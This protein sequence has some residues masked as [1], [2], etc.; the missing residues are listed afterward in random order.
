MQKSRKLL[1]TRQTQNLMLHVRPCYWFTL[2]LQYK[3]TGFT[4]HL[5]QCFACKQLPWQGPNKKVANE[6]YRWHQ[7]KG[8]SKLNHIYICSLSWL[9][10]YGAFRGFWGNFFELVAFIRVYY[11]NWLSFGQFAVVMLQHMQKVGSGARNASCQ[12][13][14]LHKKSNT[15]FLNSQFSAWHRVK[16]TQPQH[17]QICWMWIGWVNWI[18]HLGP[19][20]LCV[21]NNQ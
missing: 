4:N 17:V 20:L 5:A 7:H 13:T 8:I 19:M 10:N 11:C 15:W 3:L 21:F 16:L 14:H 18:E 9:I 1:S 2:H 6:W 12:Q